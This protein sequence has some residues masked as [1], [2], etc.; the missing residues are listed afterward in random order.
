MINDNNQY[1]NWFRHSSPY[2]NAHRGKT[3][4][5]MLGG[6]AL[7]DDNFGNIIHDIALLNSL[8]VKL[9]LIHGSRPQIAAKLE[10]LQISDKVHHH[11]RV[12]DSDTLQCVIEAAASLRTEVEAKL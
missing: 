4:V 9:V 3:F 7:A 2:I 11:L 12:T 1:V 10:Q 5:L 6:E 8:G